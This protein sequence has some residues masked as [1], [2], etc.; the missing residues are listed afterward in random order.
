MQLL[1]SLA[2]MAAKARPTWV[3]KSFPIIRI[4]IASLIGLLAISLIVLSFCQESSS[5]GASAITGEANT[6]YNRNKGKSLQGKI[7]IVTIVNSACIVF[8]C[9]LYII[10]TAIYSGV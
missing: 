3:V 2:N 4:I 1:F 5:S 7:K 6:F 10:F 9:I 8:L